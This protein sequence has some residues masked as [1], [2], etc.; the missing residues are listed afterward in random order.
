MSEH[1][2]IST[3]N[4]HLILKAGRN[5]E[6]LQY[7]FGSRLSSPDE[8]VFDDHAHIP[9]DGTTPA[10]TTSPIIERG[11]EPAP[12]ISAF[13]AA[14]NTGS[15]R[16]T[17]ADGNLGLELT[18]RSHTRLAE[19][20]NRILT[21][22]MLED[23]SYPFMVAINYRAYQQEDVIEIWTKI[24]HQEDDAVILHQFPAAELTFANRDNNYHL[25]SFT[26]LW[27][28]EQG[29]V[30]EKL[31]PGC[32]TLENR[33]GVWPSFGFNPSFILSMDGPANEEAGEVIAGALAWSGNWK[34]SFNYDH[35]LLFYDVTERSK[36]TITAG[37]ND[38][39][40]EYRLDHHEVFESPK[41]ILAYSNCGKGQISRN[42]HRWARKYSLRDGTL[43]RPIL[44]N[45]WEGVRFAFD[46]EKLLSMMDG[47]AKMGGEMFVL[48]DGWFGNGDFARNNDDRGLGD[49]QVNLEKL[50]NGL[51]FL[52]DEAE[53][54]GLKFGIWLEPEMVNPKSNLF[55][56]HPDWVIQQN[57]RDN[58]V[59]RNQLILDMTNPDVQD[60][61]FESVANILR[62]IPGISYVK[63]DCN[64]P[65]INPGSTY[66]AADRQTHLWID[67]T[68]GLYRVYDRLVAEFPFVI[69]QACASG[70]G[71]ID[72]GIL[73][74]N[75]EFWTSDNTD[76]LQRIFIQWGTNH[77]YP[78]IATAA[79]VTICPNHQTGRNIPLKFR[80]D[81]AMTGRM[82]LE[83]NPDDMN[84]EELDFVK[85]AVQEYK[86]IRPVVMFGDL[87]RLLSPYDG[88]FTAMLYVSSDK[89]RALLFAFNINHKLGHTMPQIRLRGLD[90]NLHY[91]L[92]ELNTIDGRVHSRL[93]DT[94]LSANTLLLNG[95]R[96][97]L[98]QE[99]DSAVI[100]LTAQQ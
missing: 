49:W 16:A 6:L 1:I 86:R 21:T 4:T 57:K 61:V 64:R 9:A 27:E 83:L 80:F 36:L 45:S 5:G 44:L 52:A 74:R 60:F 85:K 95:I 17:H 69:F 99:Y 3:N 37:Q 23:R 63:W 28:R 76:A 2:V 67:Y 39:A 81:L 54:R 48:D 65:I 68:H 20:D 10:I 18:Y 40:S 89:T 24:S 7:Y 91:H 56:K 38:F 53:K 98:T 31:Y 32:K 25:T 33:Y 26:G 97:H 87:Y 70:G 78:A 19:D 55:S 88:D 8:V 12:A 94:T 14:N 62:E 29:M 71:R 58:T 15:L 35:G 47:V 90:Q 84:E 11:E 92:H 96:I 30:E 66:L 59:Y 43:E 77:I 22:V 72:Y 51:G 100:E 34:I 50:P 41:F 46:E 75:H 42:L 93:E 73:R 82:G 13:G 79:H